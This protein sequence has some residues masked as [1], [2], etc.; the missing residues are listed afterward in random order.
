VKAAVAI[1]SAA[2]VVL[3]M[4]RRLATVSPSKAPGRLRCPVGSDP[5]RARER[6]VAISPL[7]SDSGRQHRA[8]PISPRQ[9]S[10]RIRLRRGAGDK[11]VMSVEEQPP[12]PR[13]ARTHRAPA[14]HGRPNQLRKQSWPAQHRC[15]SDTGVGSWPHGR[16]KAAHGATSSVSSSSR[17][18]G[19]PNASAWCPSGVRCQSSAGLS[20]ISSSVLPSGSM[21]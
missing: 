5:A 7:L 12:G 17:S 19:W 8:Q 6:P 15:L 18:S 2:C 1:S 14:P 9:P 10:R 21:T 16:F 4:N 13:A 3:V 11:V 20:H